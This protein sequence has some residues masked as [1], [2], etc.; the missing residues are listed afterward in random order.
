MPLL[1]KAAP[2]ARVI[3]VSS[4]GMY[5]EPLNKDLQFGENNFDGTQQYARNKEFRLSGNLRS[6]DE[7]ADTVIWLALQPKEKLTS[8][9][10]YFDRAEAPKHLKFAG[11]AASHGQ[12]GSIVD[13][14]RSICGI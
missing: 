12:I 6:N 4:G 1:E 8:G 13:S 11:T 2:D 7:G 9:S 14:L 5:T 10:F 3:T